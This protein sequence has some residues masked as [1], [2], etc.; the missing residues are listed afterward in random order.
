MTSREGRPVA[1]AH[2]DAERRR[3]A[4][5]SSNG[6]KITPAA[7]RSQGQNWARTY[8][9]RCF[10]RPKRSTIPSSKITQ[11]LNRVRATATFTRVG[12]WEKDGIGCAVVSGLGIGVS[13]GA[14]RSAWVEVSFK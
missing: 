2:G 9:G 10:H 1:G 8:S 3:H 7:A 4:G 11:L 6:M 13:S 14:V 12:S 5:N